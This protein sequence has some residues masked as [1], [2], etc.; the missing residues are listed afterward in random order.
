MNWWS[1]IFEEMFICL[2]VYLLRMTRVFS[3]KTQTLRT[4]L[5]CNLPDCAVLCA[6]KTDTTFFRIN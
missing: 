2:G 5:L 4:S 1:S 3:D 6:R